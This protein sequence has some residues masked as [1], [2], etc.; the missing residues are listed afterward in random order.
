MVKDYGKICASGKSGKVFYGKNNTILWKDCPF[1]RPTPPPIVPVGMPCIIN[2]T[3]E[4]PGGANSDLDIVAFWT[5]SK[6]E[7]KYDNTNTC[8]GYSWS[9]HAWATSDDAPSEEWPTPV[10][11]ING[12]KVW[13]YGDETQHG[14]VGE[15]VR[16]DHEGDDPID[17]TFEV[18]CNWWR[19][20]GTATLT[21][22]DNEGNVLTKTI[23]PSE[24]RQSSSAQLTDH[25]FIMHFTP[26]GV[27]TELET[28]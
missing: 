5:K 24:D 18:R 23:H 21:I 28:V 4:S 25:G 15:K 2:I 16:I 14:I 6:G 9:G 13:W 1:V 27:L 17:D 26:E 8:V 19:G 12:Y 7:G 3:W 10:K 22:R 20:Q 11:Q